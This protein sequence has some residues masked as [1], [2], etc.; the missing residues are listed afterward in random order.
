LAILR[1]CF[2]LLL[3]GAM[4]GHLHIHTRGHKTLNSVPL[5]VL[6]HA[7]LSLLHAHEGFWDAEHTTDTSPCSSSYSSNSKSVC[8]CAPVLLGLRVMTSAWV[9]SM[10]CHFEVTAVPPVYMHTHLGQPCGLVALWLGRLVAQ[11]RSKHCRDRSGS[12][13]CPLFAAAGLKVEQEAPLVSLSVVQSSE[14]VHCMCEI[15]HCMVQADY[16]RHSVM[17]ARCRLSCIQHTCVRTLS[18]TALACRTT[19]LSM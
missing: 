9:T 8:C 14:T 10:P 13:G 4:S 11:Y 1:A 7:S 12:V 15:V 6:G 19:R 16:L 5:C 17:L 3:A 18:K 2:F